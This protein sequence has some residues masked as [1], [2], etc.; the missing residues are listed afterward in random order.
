MPGW[1]S[2]LPLPPALAAA[3]APPHV[4]FD[5]KWLVRRFAMAAAAACLLLAALR[6]RNEDRNHVR[7]VLPNFL[8]VF[9]V[10][11]DHDRFI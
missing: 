5:F 6:Y 11:V 1:L 8:P 7:H 9:P 10:G 2:V 3:V 4:A